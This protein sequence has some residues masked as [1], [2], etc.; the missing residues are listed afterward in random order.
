M[1]DLSGKEVEPANGEGGEEVVNASSASE[2]PAE[3]EAAPAVDAGG[4][5]LADIE[6]LI[7]DL[8]TTNADLLVQQQSAV[9]AVSDA[10]KKAADT[11]QAAAEAGS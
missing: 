2:A 9:D 5:D 10:E 4:D 7:T 1:D 8:E 11:A 3:I 6:A